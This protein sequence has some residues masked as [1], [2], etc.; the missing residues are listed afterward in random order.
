MKQNIGPL[1]KIIRL[2]IGS[3]IIALGVVFK[4]WWGLLGILPVFTALIGWCGLYQLLGK[5]T[6]P[7]KK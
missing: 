1:D 4:S 7:M 6:C 2:L 3:I 5:S